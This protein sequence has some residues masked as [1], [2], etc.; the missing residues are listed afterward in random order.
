MTM[1]YGNVTRSPA[2][3][4]ER[5]VGRSEEMN[6]VALR[7][8]EAAPWV[9][10]VDD[11]PLAGRAAARLIMGI[12]GARVTIVSN[13]T[14]AL[15]LATRAEVAPSAVVLDYDLGDGEKGLTVLLSLR[16]GGFEAPCA[17]HTGAPDRAR[18]ALRKS[19]LG[20]GYPVFDKGV[21]GDRELVEWLDARL[22]HTEEK[23][24]PHR[25][26]IREKLA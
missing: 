4:R 1:F 8:Q 10:V 13:V 9:L 24:S 22:P 15:R 2:S 18:S 3:A 26:G 16:A 7:R 25:S 17:F 14:Q 21:V 12:T 19:R 20:D 23:D 11:D 5:R 6:Q